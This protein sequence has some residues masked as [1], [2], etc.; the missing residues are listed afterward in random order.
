MIICPGCAAVEGVLVDTLLVD[1]L[2]VYIL[3]PGDKEVRLEVYLDLV[4]PL[5]QRHVPSDVRVDVVA[6]T[7]HFF[8]PTK[9]GVT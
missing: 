1:V 4:G 9:A 7:V 3:S 6:A 8:Q 5:A 2:L